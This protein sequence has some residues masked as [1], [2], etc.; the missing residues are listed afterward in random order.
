MSLWL[1]GLMEAHDDQPPVEQ[2]ELEVHLAPEV[3]REPGGLVQV[4]AGAEIT[5]AR[6]AARM[7]IPRGDFRKTLAEGNRNG[8][9]AANADR[10]TISTKPVVVLRLPAVPPTTAAAS[11]FEYR[12]EVTL[13]AGLGL[14]R[15]GPREDVIDT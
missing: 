3:R 2:R 4:V 11:L 14:V 15:H 8:R 1:G 6:I 7:E 5:V 9:F 13:S 10:F 12:T